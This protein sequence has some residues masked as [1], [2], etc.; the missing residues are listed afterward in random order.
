MK[1]W[2]RLTDESVLA[3]NARSLRIVK[4]CPPAPTSAKLTTFGYSRPDPNQASIEIIESKVKI[5]PYILSK[6][7]CELI[8]EMIDCHPIPGVPPF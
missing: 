2:T 6:A 1:V 5:T 8:I 4:V 7:C 3:G